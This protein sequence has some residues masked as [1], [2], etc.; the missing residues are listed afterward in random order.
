M[1]TNTAKK[2]SLKNDSIEF[3]FTNFGA[4]WIEAFVSDKS[5]KREDILQGYD[6]LSTYQSHVNAY[7]AVC[8]RVANRIED[9]K[10]D[11]EGKTY[12]LSE[13]VKGATLHGGPTGF[14]ARM[15]TTEEY[16]GDKV[17][18]TYF[19]EDGEEG[20]PGNVQVRVSYALQGKQTLKMEL[21]AESDCPT[22]VNL[23]SHPY[24]NLSGH[25][26]G[27]IGTQ[28]FQIFAENI[29]PMNEYFI[30]KG[31]KQSVASTEFDLRSPV[32]ITERLH[33][34]NPQIILAGGFDH[35]YI[36]KD[37]RNSSLLQ[38]AEIWD[39]NSGRFMKIH[40]T[41][42]GLQFYTCNSGNERPGKGEA[43]YIKWGSFCME[44]QYFPNSPNVPDFPDTIV[45]PGYPMKEVNIFEFGQRSK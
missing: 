4:R 23:A 19:S 16:T 24:F 40:T 31:E 34:V 18:F 26:S 3:V 11:L 35:N 32:K 14:Q 43:K 15:W 41:M 36:L 44:P 42:P 29:F 10:F 17:V 21:E 37:E 45:R 30:V 5:G 6:E 39:E 9:A 13:N 1:G 25:D 20:Y 38:A 33:S 22:P 28:L 8:G 7:G 12:F 2:Y 27:S